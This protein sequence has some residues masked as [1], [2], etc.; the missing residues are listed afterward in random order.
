MVLGWTKVG[1]S[2]PRARGTVQTPNPSTG[3]TRFIPASAGNSQCAPEP[4]LQFPVHPRERGEQLSGSHINDTLGGSSPRAR[5]TERLARSMTAWSRFIPASAGNSR[6]LQAFAVERAVHPRERGEQPGRDRIRHPDGGSSPRARGTACLAM[7]SGQ[8]FRFIPASAGNSSELQV[9]IHP[10]AVHPRERGEQNS[11]I[12]RNS[13]RIGSS[14]RARGTAPL[15]QGELQPLRFIPA[16]AGN[17]KGPQPTEFSWPVHPRERGEQGRVLA[18][19]HFV[20]GSSPR[21]RGTGWCSGWR[22]PRRRFIPA[23]AGNSSPEWDALRAKRGSSPRARGTGFPLGH[24]SPPEW[25]IPASAGNRDS[26][27]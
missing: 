9:P 3:R 13:D 12:T 21:A 27:D 11:L 17:S 6:L 2:S 25:F 24:C 22:W 4:E 15:I 18:G 16:S 5:G 7:I 10:T 8:R 23:S 20:A 19:R 26:N 1:G 14:P